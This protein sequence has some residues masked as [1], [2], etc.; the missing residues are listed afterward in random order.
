MSRQKPQS[1][2]DRYPHF[3][4]KQAE[5]AKIYS[6]QGIIRMG[7]PKPHRERLIAFSV[8]GFDGQKK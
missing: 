3:T 4:K 7:S 1:N 6:L 8:G 2:T 5:M